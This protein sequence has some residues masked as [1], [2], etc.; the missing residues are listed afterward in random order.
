MLQVK[1][2]ETYQIL[3]E[4]TDEDVFAI[5]DNDPLYL[6]KFCTWMTL[7]YG[8]KLTKNNGK[9]QDNVIN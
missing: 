3:N 4:L 7:E 8:Q 5:L 2:L 9:N 1:D 6:V